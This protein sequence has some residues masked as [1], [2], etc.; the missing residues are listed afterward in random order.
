V[1]DIC[2]VHLVRKKNGIEPFRNFLDSYLNHPA[3][4][5][6][7]LL[8]LFKGFSGSS[9]ITPYESLLKNTPHTFL[10]LP[11]TGFDLGPYFVAAERSNCRYLCF[12]NSFS[13][14]QAND[15]LLKLYRQITKPGVGL[16]GATGSWGSM[17]P[18]RLTT[19]KALPLWKKLLRPLVWRMIRAYFRLYFEPFPNSHIRTNGFMVSRDAMLKIRRG[20]LL[21]KM[22]AYRLESGKNS[23]T[24]QIERMGLEAIVVGKDGVGYGKNEWDVSN[25]FWSQAQSNLLIADNQTRKY[26]AEEGEQRSRWERFAWGRAADNPHG[27][28]TRG[29]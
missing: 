22:H 5:G 15:W 14:V 27:N 3:G 26:D 29:A 9:D 13:L 28:E 20:P 7:E 12:L 23:I 4:V 11:D 6:H 19:K 21:T 25:T 10:V 24:R 8:I 18:G 17:C 16:V 2:V 1:P